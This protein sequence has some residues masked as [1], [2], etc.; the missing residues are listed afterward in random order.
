ML[1]THKLHFQFAV[2]AKL[3]DMT[4]GP[5]IA[6][7]QFFLFKL[8]FPTLAIKQGIKTRVTSCQIQMTKME[9]KKFHT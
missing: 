5:Q 7:F 8:E 4:L 2:F 3:Y 9:E 6:K 1:E